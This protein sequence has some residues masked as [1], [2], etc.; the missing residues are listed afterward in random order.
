MGVDDIVVAGYIS[1]GDCI[2]LEMFV[3]QLIWVSVYQVL[4]ERK[5][6]RCDRHA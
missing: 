1:G 4:T 2:Q 5:T 6:K 3:N